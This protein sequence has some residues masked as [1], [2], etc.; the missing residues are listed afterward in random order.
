MVV[1]NAYISVPTYIGSITAID[2]TFFS[3]SGHDSLIT[4]H[5]NLVSG[6]MLTS[7]AYLKVQGKLYMYTKGITTKGY[8]CKKTLCG[9]YICSVSK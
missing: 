4:C 8:D 5:A 9:D 6:M 1:Q 7:T 2:I 3:A